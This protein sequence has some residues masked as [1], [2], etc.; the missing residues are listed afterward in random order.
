LAPLMAVFFEFFG[1]Y[2]TERP[3]EGM[4]SVN[5]IRYAVL[6]PLPILFIIAVLFKSFKG[7]LLLAGM[8]WVFWIYLMFTYSCLV[9]LSMICAIIWFRDIRIRIKRDEINSNAED[10]ARKIIEV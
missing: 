5:I 1:Q 2:T 8:A 4:F 3:R 6:V 9:A 7:S 10:A